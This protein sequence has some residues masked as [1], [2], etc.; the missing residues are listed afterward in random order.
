LARRKG[1]G[2]D[3]RAALLQA[4]L[5]L[6]CE[7]GFDGCSVDAIASRAS[8]SKGTFFHFFKSKQALLDAACEQV[9][10]DAWNAVRP[11]LEGNEHDALTRLEQFF[12]LSRSWRLDQGRPLAR[13]WRAL[14]RDG[15][16]AMLAKV[17]LRHL[18]LVQPAFARLIAE[19]NAHGQFRVQDTEMTA[20]L[21]LE[22]VTTS[23][24]RDMAMLL[25]SR[26]DA[27][28][29]ALRRVNQTLAAVERVLGAGEGVLQRMGDESLT[30]C[31]DGPRARTESLSAGARHPVGSTPRA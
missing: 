26:E 13:L 5:E 14:S 29:A 16:V 28:G 31:A 19:G 27:P 6:A 22:W 24:E 8:L 23:A 2:I 9:A 17:R 25:D 30:G 21:L 20:A 15:N 12:E 4:A 3:T 11:A 7:R 1:K 18:E 10:A